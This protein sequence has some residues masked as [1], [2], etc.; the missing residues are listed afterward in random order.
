MP[1]LALFYHM[2][3]ATKYKN[4]LRFL[5]YFFFIFFVYEL[6]CSFHIF[7]KLRKQDVLLPLIQ[8]SSN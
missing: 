2:D 5:F 3:E 8:F 4:I 7:G 6:K 1:N